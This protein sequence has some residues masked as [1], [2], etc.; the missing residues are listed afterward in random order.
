MVSPSI[1]GGEEAISRCS[2]SANLIYLSTVE[3]FPK[4]S[5][6]SDGRHKFLSASQLEDRDREQTPKE[7][8]R[9]RLKH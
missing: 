6:R 3:P 8:H 2:A 9:G 1:R 4:P 5:S 7:H